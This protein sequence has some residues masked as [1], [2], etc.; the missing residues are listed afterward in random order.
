MLKKLKSWFNKEQD[1]IILP[2][3]KDKDTRFLLSVD[4]LKI[5]YLCSRHGEWYFEYTEEFQKHSDYNRIIGFPELNKVY[6]SEELWPFFRIR[7][8]GLKQ[9]VVQEILQKEKIDK[10]DEVELL[11]RFGHKT[12]ANPYEL[13]VG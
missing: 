11:K 9:P 8:P 1:D 4:N 7:I 12:I 2:L 10:N 13:I 3:P 6:K 5:G